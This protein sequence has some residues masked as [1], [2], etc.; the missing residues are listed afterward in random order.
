MRHGPQSRALALDTG[1][2]GMDESRVVRATPCTLHD[3]GAALFITAAAARALAGAMNGP[4]A[5]VLVVAGPRP[6]ASPAPP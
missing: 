4:P 1:R 5:R 2:T 3:D 6:S